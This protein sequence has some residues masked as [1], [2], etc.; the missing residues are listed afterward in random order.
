MGDVVRVPLTEL[1]R[2]F[3][4]AFSCCCKM[5][6]TERD[7]VLQEAEQRACCSTLCDF[8]INVKLSLCS[9]N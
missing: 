6:M 1:E 2:L 5:L 7:H 4:S 8:S 9:S 3:S